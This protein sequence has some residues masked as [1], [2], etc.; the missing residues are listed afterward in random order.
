[1]AL[2]G[3]R[4]QHLNHLHKVNQQ[5]PLLRNR[6]RQESRFFTKR[7]GGRILVLGGPSCVGKTTIQKALCRN[8]QNSRYEFTHLVTCTTRQPRPGEVHSV[9][10]RF[11]TVDEYD[12]AGEDMEERTCYNGIRYGTLRRDLD[13]AGSCPPGVITVAALDAVGLSFLRARCGRAGAGSVLGIFLTA[14]LHTLE[15]RLRARGTD[16]ATL[17]ARLALAAKTEL[18]PEYQRHYDLAI[19]NDDGQSVDATRALVEEACAAWFDGDGA[20][21]EAALPRVRKG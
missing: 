15:A 16:P 2:F 9:D 10:Y 17:E 8:A 3:L 11:F 5:A 13:A 18:T 21:R 19:C 20:D 7:A 12:A 1:M 14:S 6:T 4:L